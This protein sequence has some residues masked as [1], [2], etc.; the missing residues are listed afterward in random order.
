MEPSNKYSLVGAKRL[1]E[2]IATW[3]ESIE[4]HRK[5][6]E[7][8]ESLAIRQDKHQRQK[9]IDELNEILTNNSLTPV[10]AVD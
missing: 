4:K 5:A 8:E 6:G 1:L 10:K 9:F 3:N 2:L 7:L